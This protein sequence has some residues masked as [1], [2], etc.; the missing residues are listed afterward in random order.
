MP[1]FPDA[2]P[3]P[4]ST[5]KMR[6][7]RERTM[8]KTIVWGVIIRLCI[9]VG[10]LIGVTLFG[11]LSLLL[12]AIASFIDVV[13]SLILLLFIKLAGRPPDAE[14]PFG[15]GRYEPLAGL[16]LGL[17]LVLIGSG[18]FIQ[19]I[20]HLSMTSHEVMDQRAWIFPV[21]AL[22]LLE[23]CYAMTMR[24]ARKYNS[25]ALIADAAHY[26][27]DS[28]TTLLAT[29]ALIVAAYIPQ[30]SGYIDHLGAIAI[31]MLMIG[32]GVY[33]TRKNLDQLLDR[34]PAQRY[35]EGVRRAAKAVPG[36]EDT[37]KLLIQLSG[38]DAHVDIDI[39]VDPQLSVEKAHEIS[40]KVRAGIQK[41]WP[42]V[43]EVM[44]HIEPYYPNDH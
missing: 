25:P 29:I 1:R 39:E 32:L 40:Q 42:A 3:P 33:A 43:R 26:R 18:M 16:Q 27:I 28:L 38:P 4:L 44:V 23:I 41:E 9:I 15:H 20:W 36:V 37:E 13:S 7:E 21:C 10:E 2:V 34:V 35:F 30:W 22:I 12:D 19:Q 17:L 5:L 8:R 31:S 11:S 14:H 6:T 24:A